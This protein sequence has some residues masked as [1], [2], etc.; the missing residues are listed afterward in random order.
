MELFITTLLGSGIGAAL[1]TGWFSVRNS[2][3]AVRV[4]NITKERMKW[5]D[6]IRRIA[7]EIAEVKSSPDAA[8]YSKLRIELVTRLNPT[9]KYDKEILEC[10]DSY[11]NDAE[12]SEN[13][14][15]LGNRIALLLKHDWERAKWEAS[16]ANERATRPPCRCRFSYE[17]HFGNDS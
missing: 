3:K 1:V 15:A 4:E 8:M 16:P 17:K 11:C 5:R 9:D 10:F 13:L 2:D 14:I 6:E 12:N 7:E